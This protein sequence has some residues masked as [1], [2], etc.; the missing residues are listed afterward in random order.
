[1]VSTFEISIEEIGQ[2]SENLKEQLIKTKATSKEVASSLLLMEEII[3]R[4]QGSSGHPV[5]VQI[6]KQLGD[7]ALSLSSHGDEY[8]PLASLN[9]W[10]IENE[11][12][13]RDQ[14]LRAYQAN[15]SY[16]RKN[17]N[18]IV[19]INVHDAENRKVVITFVC[20]LAG[21]AVGLGLKW[22]PQAAADYITDNIFNTVQTLFLNAMSLLLAPVVFFSIAT[23]LS[24]L[25]GS[26]EAGRIGGKVLSSYLV[27]TVIA[28]LIGFG[29]A[30]LFFSGN[31]PKLPAGLTEAASEF[32]NKV[33][34][35]LKTIL[36][37]II[38][39]NIVQPILDRNM[40]QVIFTAVLCGLA[41]SILGDKTSR[42][43][44]I[45]GEANTL[46]LKMMEMVISFIPFAAFASM[47]ILVYDCEGSTLFMLVKYLLALAA[48]TTVLL[49]LYMSMIIVI[50]HISPIPYA[51]KVSMYLLTPFTLASSSVCIPLT[52]DFCQRKLGV[53]EKI[54]SFSIPLGATINMNGCAMSVALAVVMLSKM[55]G[56]DLALSDWVEIGIMIILLSAGAPG[57][58]NTGLVIIATLLSTTSVPA[59]ALGFLIGIWNI[60]DRIDTAANVNGDIATGV[61]VAANEKELNLETYKK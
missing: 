9:S 27:T 29:V 42:V 12:Y 36:L 19:T 3:V 24:K 38:P 37:G 47:A 49:L 61:V 59:G 31:V 1:M 55:C 4:L 39:K 50:G 16:C 22:I 35:S 57:V 34:V 60:V 5:K 46:F 7:V 10:D 23:S 58:P 45:V 52:I 48:G 15:L 21:I 11:E 13:C 30:F 20:M 6:K 14:I 18:N 41:L 28:V 2:Q 26:N 51:R 53:S 17:G 43:R 32:D 25:S 8:N 40:L 54:S 44:N 56:V 33:E